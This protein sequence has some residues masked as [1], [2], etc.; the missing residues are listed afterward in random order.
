MEPR[1]PSRA[2]TDDRTA[3]AIQPQ[4]AA[5]PARGTDSEPRPGVLRGGATLTLQTHQAQRLVKGRGYSAEKPAI[6]GLIGFANLLR[7]IWHGARADDP[8]AD[9]WLLKVHAALE[10]AEQTIAACEQELTVQ[11]ATLDALEVVAP[12]SVKPVRVPLH[13]SNPYAFRAARLLGAY[14]SLA[15]TALSV[16]HIGLMPR[17]EVERALHLG[18]RQVRRALQSAVGYRLLGVTRGEL[19]HGTHQTAAASAAM[20]EL[21]DDVLSGERRAPYAPRI[22]A[23]AAA[24]PLSLHPL[25]NLT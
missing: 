10:Q 25:P 24:T 4:A 17:D 14:D 15:R 16:R 11:L 7:S 5:T 20:G 19:A 3:S 21:P 8:Y 22:V 23:P 6:I 9:W 13:F 2:R 1:D 18:G 12:V